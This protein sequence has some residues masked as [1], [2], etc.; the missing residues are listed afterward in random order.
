MGGGNPNE[1]RRTEPHTLRAKFGVD[2]YENAVYGS[3]GWH[4]AA[5][6]ACVFFH[7]EMKGCFGKDPGEN[8]WEDRDY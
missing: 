1:A 2:A 3:E 8:Y 7:S 6:E 5:R 4:D